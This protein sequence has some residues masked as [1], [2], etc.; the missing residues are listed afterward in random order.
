[1]SERA[2]L[3]LL[4]DCNASAFVLFACFIR[5]VC[6]VSV[7]CKSRKE[8]RF[9]AFLFFHLLQFN[10]VLSLSLY[11]A[12]ARWLFAAITTKETRRRQQHEW[13]EINSRFSLWKSLHRTS[14][15]AFYHIYNQHVHILL[16]LPG[17]S[18]CFVVVCWLMKKTNLPTNTIIIIIIIISN[19][20]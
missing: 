17:F 4:V 3:S 1:M 12:R 5:I 13:D 19:N 2:L 7:N 18:F 14:Q 15:L 16:L 11:I 6:F 20:N 9:V 8:V 10:F